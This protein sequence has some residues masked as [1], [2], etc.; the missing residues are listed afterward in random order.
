LTKTVE[1]SEL[2]IFWKTA[3]PHSWVIVCSFQFT[4]CA[5]AVSLQYSVHGR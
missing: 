3:I 4:D 1:A 5:D 2:Q